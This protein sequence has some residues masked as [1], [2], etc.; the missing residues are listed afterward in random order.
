MAFKEDESGGQVED[1]SSVKKYCSI[2]A[3]GDDSKDHPHCLF[4]GLALVEQ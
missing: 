1:T 4:I 2:Q 3:S